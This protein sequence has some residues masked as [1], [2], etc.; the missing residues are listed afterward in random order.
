LREALNTARKVKGF[1]VK[2]IATKLGIS[3]SFYYKIEKGLRNP[4]IDLAK[5]ISELLE[6]NIEELFLRKNWTNRLNK[7][8]IQ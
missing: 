3:E 6:K 7:E 4:N 8:V 5:K 1:T 2:D